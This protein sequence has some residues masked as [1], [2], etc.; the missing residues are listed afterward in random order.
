MAVKPVTSDA[1]YSTAIMKRKI[2]FQTEEAKSFLGNKM[3]NIAVA[4]FILDV[5]SRK[6]IARLN[7]STKDHKAA[8]KALNKLFTDFEK[9]IQDETTR[10]EAVLK[11]QKIQGRAEHNNPGSYE[12]E[13]TTPELKRAVDLLLAFDN[14]I[15]LVDTVWLMGIMETDVANQFR[16]T[17]AGQ[18]KRL[19]GSVYKLSQAAKQSAFVKDDADTQAVI[20]REEKK[21]EP[22]EEQPAAAEPQ[23]A[24]SQDAA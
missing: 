4:L 16:A 24:D 17:K 18:I 7:L 11:A 20:A 8:S 6:R 9:E 22:Q 19:F 13:I 12:V 21:L 1:P 10:L 14:L 5:I 2:T 15:V 23:P 3:D